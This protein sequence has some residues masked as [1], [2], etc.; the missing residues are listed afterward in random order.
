MWMPVAGVILA[1]YCRGRSP[2]ILRDVAVHHSATTSARVSRI[3]T[4]ESCDEWQDWPPEVSAT[5][6]PAF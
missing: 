4:G 3:E 5:D 2:Q 1:R 6:Q